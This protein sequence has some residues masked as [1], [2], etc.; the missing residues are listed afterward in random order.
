MIDNE[1]RQAIGYG[2]GKL[3]EMRRKNE[4]YFLGLPKEDLAPPEIEGRSSVVDTTGRN[5][6]LG[7]E[8]PLIKTFYG[9]DNIVEFEETKEGDEDAAKQATDY[10]NYI[11][12]KKN[13]GY[14]IISTW[15]RDALVQKKG[16]IK[17]WWDASKIEARE[18]YRGQTDVQLAILLD[19]DEVEPIEQRSYPDPDAEKQKAKIV[20]QIDQQLQQMAAAAQ[21]AM[22]QPVDV[23]GQ[24]PQAIAQFQQAMAEA[25]QIKAQPLPMLYDVT[26]KRVKTGGKVCIENVPPEEFLISRT[27]KSIA[28][29]PFTAHR[30]QRTIGQLRSAGYKDLDDLGSDDVGAQLSTER[31]ERVAYDDYDAY[32]EDM[33][34][35]ADPTM[36]K[37]WILECYVQA[38]YDGDGIPEW[39]KVVR[40]GDRLLENVECDGPPFVD[41]GSIPLP[42]R[43]F[44]L[45]PMDLAIEPQR[46]QTSLLR[47][48]LDNVYLQVNG[49][50]FA[51][52]NQVNLDDLLTSRPGGIV[53]VKAQGAVG[54]LDQG[55][56]D[57]GNA[58]QLMAW[59]QDYTEES[60]GWTRQSQGGNGKGVPKQQTLGEANIVTNRA[61]SRIEIISRQFAE[62]GFTDLF[63]RILK[64]VTQYQ[65]KAEMLKLGGKWQNIDP[66]E[67]VNQF[68]LT[69]NVG[70]G[71][72]N[73]DQQVQHLQ[74]MGQKQMEGL[75]LGIVKPKQVY[76]LDVKMAEAL[77]FKNGS[78]FFVDPEAPPDPNAPPPPPPPP[79]PAV[80][81]AQADEQRY[82]R[83]LQFKQQ[84]ADMDRQATLQAKQMEAEAQMQVDRNRHEVEAQRQTLKLQN[85]AQLDAQKAEYA[86]VQ[87][88]AQLELER[89]KIALEQYKADLQAQ[90]ATVVAQIRAGQTNDPTLTA[91]EDAANQGAA[92][93][94]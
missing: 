29:A 66:R 43:F 44:G 6:I 59:Y 13:P 55:A 28:T 49:R 93:G 81:K 63:R 3:E 91:A 88:M 5:T 72:G 92:S 94:N 20:E 65:D 53:R 57:S 68:N 18:E 8:A 71:T 34:E 24:P 31:I 36:R 51:V 39:R 47:A 84:Q 56:G 64:L 48:Q 19:D 69:I 23:Q 42:H 45:C 83:E 82:Q 16:F 58:M 1:M 74:I 2:T 90:T 70:I 25:E 4:Y 12:R 26:V 32:S 62:T 79:D 37:V 80:V 21:Q 33:T 76:N 75:Q 38:D 78:Q 14:T 30:L 77:G 60:T 9:T 86:H 87:Q 73:K 35:S 10:C 89:E 22:Q 40:C 67:W 46:I 7:M 54:R 52:E 41:L 15:I 11:L 50:Y 85:E 61:D 27:A 17:V